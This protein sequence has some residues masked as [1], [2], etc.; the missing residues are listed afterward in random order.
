MADLARLLAC[1]PYL[2]PQS[3]LN[4][5]NLTLSASG[6]KVGWAM[7]APAA[8]TVT[9]L[10]F[11]FGTRTGTPPTYRISLQGLDASGNPDGTVL[12]GGNPASGTFT[13]PASTAWNSAWQW[14]TLA[15]SYTT[16]R[17]QFLAV[18]IDYSAG[19]ID[20]SN[21]GSFTYAVN[22]LQPCG[23][24]GAPYAL[25]NTAGWSK[26]TSSG[27]SY[28]CVGLKSS[29]SV[30][31]Y[32]IVTAAT[33]TGSDITTNANRAA[34]R[35]LLPSGAG[36]TFKVAGMRF[37]MTTPASANYKVGI[38]DGT[39]AAI[40]TVTVDADYAI[41]LG[42]QLRQM[43]VFFQ[44]STLATLN[45][46]TAYYAGLERT[47]VQVT[48]HTTVLNSA[49]ELKAVYGGDGLYLATWNGSAW[50]A[51]QT[52]RPYVELILDDATA[53]SGSGS[54]GAVFL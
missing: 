34:L 38:W 49:T 32:P 2:W 11:R 8:D 37:S 42:S 31:G 16:T 26:V 25:T 20:A 29:G 40:Q 23:R 24:T 30:Y 46:G 13:P 43:E 35:F 33:G 7:Q 6:S 10:G 12:G 47:T 21:C 48:L 36:T 51:D 39:G 28:G 41:A 5:T 19:T 50:T 45:Y 18:V 54:G 44:D 4:Y 27:D 14:V 17:G 9:A 3:G 15:S 22:G 1:G 53:L 52:Q